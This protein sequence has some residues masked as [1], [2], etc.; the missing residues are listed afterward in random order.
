MDESEITRKI[1]S[2]PRWHYEFD[3]GGHK[4]PIWDATHVNRHL[5]RKRYFFDPL[6]ELL[7][8]SLAGKRVLDVGCNAGFWSLCAI[9]AGA[10]FVLGI[11]GRQM[12]V[13]QA[14][15]V[16]DVKGVDP[17]RYRF[18]TGNIFT[19]DLREHGSFEIVLCLGLMYHVSKPFELVERISAANTDLLLIDTT[20]STA[21][22]SAFE[23]RHD[24]L[25]EPRNAVDYEVVL[26]PTRRA[27]LD[28]VRQFGYS[29][30]ILEPRFTDY[31]GSS[32]YRNRTRRAFICAKR[33]DLS[34]LKAPLESSNIGTM[35]ADNLQWAA[36]QMRRWIKRRVQK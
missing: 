20:L 5:Q 24:A 7:G 8:G 15:F 25:D 36:Q 2:F 34:R 3:L 10:D 33:T 13:D 32:V 16:F 26:Y 14:N 23:V 9:E 29:A 6:V 31:A 11:D 22:G 28:V 4:T 21:P 19:T 12:H 18:T 1:A 27:V 17:K 30:V 35:L